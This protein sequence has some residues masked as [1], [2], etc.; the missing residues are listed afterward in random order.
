MPCDR[1]GMHMGGG[2]GGS[3]LASNTTPDTHTA[4]WPVL[5]ADCVLLAAEAPAATVAATAHAAEPADACAGKCSPVAPA[6]ERSAEDLERDVDEAIGSQAAAS[7]EDAEVFAAYKPAKIMMGNPHPDSCVETSALGAVVPPDGLPVPLTELPAE[8]VDNGLLSNVQLE[9]IEYA[10]MRH[11]YD[12]PSG[13]R[14]GFLLGDGAGMGKGRQIAGLIYDNVRKGRTKHIWISSSRDLA[15]DA[16]RDFSD[17]GAESIEVFNLGKISA[18]ARVDSVLTAGVLFCT[19]SCLINN[20]GTT[21]HSRTRLEQIMEWTDGEEFDGCLVFD[22]C[23]KAKSLLVSKT[24][25]EKEGSKTGQKVQTIQ[26]LN[27]HAR[28]VYV[29]ATGASDLKHLSYMDRLGLWGHGTS[30]K[31]ALDFV[32][33]LD[34]RG[35]GVL[36]MLAM[37]LKS[38]GMFLA[39][40]L[41]YDGAEFNIQEVELP[42][43]Y[44]AMYDQATE[45]WEQMQTDFDSMKTMILERCIL[46]QQE[47]RSV[48]AIWSLFWASHQAF[49]KQLCMGA[50]VP[51]IIEEAK[52]ALGAGHCVVIGL[53]STGEARIDWFVEE[54]Y[55]DE[56]TLVSTAESLLM[57]LIRTTFKVGDEFEAEEDKIPELVEARDRL[58]TTVAQLAP[59]L[60]HNPLD[61][62]INLLGGPGNVAEMTGRSHR[63]VQVNNTLRYERRSPESGVRVNIAERKHFQ[64]GSKLI[65]IL[66]DASSTGISLQADRRVPNQR[67]RVH[68]TLELPWS[69]DKCVQQLGRSHRSNQSSAPVYK[70]MI[71]SIG[72]EY[73]FASAVAVRLQQLGALTKG[74]RKGA[75]GDSGAMAE[76]NVQTKEGKAALKELITRVSRVAQHGEGVDEASEKFEFCNPTEYTMQK[77]SDEAW[78]AFHRLEICELDKPFFGHDKQMQTFLN[79]LF[80]IKLE[81]QSK[82]FAAFLQLMHHHINV[83][84]INSEY[85]A[86]KIVDISGKLE[87]SDETNLWKQDGKGSVEMIRVTQ[88]RGIS[89]ADAVASL[90]TAQQAG[91]PAAFLK[92]KNVRVGFPHQDKYK[93]ILL[94]IGMEQTSLE[95]MQFYSVQRANTG[96]QGESL[97]WNSLMEKHTEVI[98]EAQLALAEK[99]WTADYQNAAH[100][101]T[102][103]KQPCTKPDCSFGGRHKSYLVLT[104]SL[105]T[106][107]PAIEAC[108]GT[109]KVVRVDVCDRRVVGLSV[110][111]QYQAQVL[112]RIEALKIQA[113]ED[114][115]Q[116]WDSTQWKEAWS[117]EYSRRYWYA[118]SAWW[119]FIT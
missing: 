23:H 61:S 48:K 11:E 42:G 21:N 68:I 87:I 6:K 24:S 17:I 32:Q 39:R 52:L 110:R 85:N 115:R 114:L 88:D 27:P 46:T 54:G 89:W 30:F 112:Q 47:Q 59:S 58:L 7:G 97:T 40:S 98:G 82:I 16:K 69:A 113:A 106:V 74:D 80:G 50:K 36:E 53:Q 75:T 41:S 31:N 1:L 20:G 5:P 26:K 2:G 29:S 83:A 99:T 67:R 91:R 94:C 37:D 9:M 60:P 63:I 56:H 18:Q 102:C 14:A 117:N 12:L 111:E 51:G 77:F 3:G 22:E 73:R 65:A 103:R 4:S 100:G 38:R 28:V 92:S 25:L 34:K 116:T 84:K 45:L 71:S 79:R 105:F 81:L 49:F 8:L 93:T 10:N 66:S 13:E 15:D 33:K 101:C 109:S 57:Y 55:W 72:P 96:V 108:L 95:R 90:E 43:E 70:L 44:V 19:Y 35:V 119:H 118:L 64:S 107:W 104:G 62:L 76:F 86:D 78:H